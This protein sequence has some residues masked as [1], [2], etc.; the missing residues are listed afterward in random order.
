MRHVVD[1]TVR[2]YRKL[3]RVVPDHGFTRIRRN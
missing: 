1:A 3:G 2:E